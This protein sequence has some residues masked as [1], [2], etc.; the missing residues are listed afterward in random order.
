MRNKSG[1][2]CPRTMHHQTPHFKLKSFLRENFSEYVIKTS[3]TVTYGQKRVRTDPLYQC[4]FCGIEKRKD[5]LRNHLLR[6]WEQNDKLHIPH[7]SANVM[8]NSSAHIAS[9]PNC[10]LGRKFKT[11]LLG[12]TGKK[13]MHGV[14]RKNRRYNNFMDDYIKETVGTVNYNSRSY[15]MH[16]CL[17]CGY[18]G[19][20]F[21][22]AN[23]IRRCWRRNDP[24]HT[25]NMTMN[26]TVL[27][28]FGTG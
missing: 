6:K 24:A 3:R 4:V 12:R 11:T 15:S 5:T 1:I 7:S 13:V 10:M 27:N 18:K 23:H 22:C 26:N 2:N 25:D 20:K 16:E 28:K 17:F 14:S 21:N 8:G 9:I 19:A